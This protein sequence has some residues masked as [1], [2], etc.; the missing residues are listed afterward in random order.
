MQIRD[1]PAVR[2]G[3]AKYTLVLTGSSWAHESMW[4]LRRNTIVHFMLLWYSNRWCC[5]I[6]RPVARANLSTAFTRICSIGE[7]SIWLGLGGQAVVVP[8]HS[9]HYDYTSK[10]PLQTSV[11]VANTF[12]QGGGPN[13][14]GVH[15]EI[16]VAV[17]IPAKAA[18]VR[19]AS[20]TLNCMVWPPLLRS[21]VVSAQAA[22]FV[23]RS[24]QIAANIHR[25]TEDELPSTVERRN[26]GSGITAV[27]GSLVLFGY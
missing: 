13:S 26:N 6:L 14:L 1:G 5:L 9:E 27:V 8:S 18:R 22:F 21:L 24:H 25:E 16:G 10:L 19:R 2:S 12:M 4:T 15:G 11:R 17:A 7:R 20:F 3:Q 23:R